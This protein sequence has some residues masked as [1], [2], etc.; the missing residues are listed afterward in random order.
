MCLFPSVSRK[1]KQV[2]LID[3]QNKI[4]KQGPIFPVLFTHLAERKTKPTKQ[5]IQNFWDH[6][7]A[8]GMLRCT[9]KTEVMLTRSMFENI[10]TE[11]S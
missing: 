7:S 4:E 9:G 10:L 5:K 6:Q 3:V 8:D 1:K 11:R 2:L